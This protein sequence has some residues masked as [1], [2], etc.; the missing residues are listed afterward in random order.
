MKIKASYPP[1]ICSLNRISPMFV[2][3]MPNWKLDETRKDP[4]S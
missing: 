4:Q 2:V 3:N 1:L